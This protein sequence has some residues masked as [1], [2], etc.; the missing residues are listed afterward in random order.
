MI[1]QPSRL[2]A[3]AAAAMGRAAAVLRRSAR[4]TRCIPTRRRCSSSRRRR[5]RQGGIE[6]WFE[7][8]HEDFGVDAATLPQADRHARRVVRFGLD[9]PDGDGRS[10]RPRDEHA[11][12]HPDGHRLPGRPLPRRLRPAS[13]LVPFVA[14]RSSCMLN[15][16][17]PYKAL[18]THGFAV[19]GEGRKMSKSKGNVVAP[20]KVSD[21]LGA[22]N[23]AAVGRAR[24]T[25]RATSSI[26]DEILKRVVESYRRIRNTLRFLIAN[27]ADFDAGAAMRVA[28]GRAVRDR[29]LRARAGA[30]AGRR[31]SPA[32]YA[33]YEFHLVVQRLQTY[34]SED[35]GG[36]Y[37]DVLK[38]RLYT[39]ARD[40]RAP[41][42]G[43][44]GARADPRRA[45]AADGADPVVHGRGGVADRAS[46]GSDDLRAH[47]GRRAAAR[48]P[49]ADALR[50]EVGH[51]SSAV[52]ARVQKELEA[53]A[54][55]RARS[56]HRCR[57]TSTI[58]APDADVSRR[59]RS[60]GDDL[61]FVLITSAATRRRAAT[62]LARSPSRRA[63][64]RSASAAGTGAPTSAPI[65]RIRRCAVAASRTCS[66]RASRAR[67]PEP[68]LRA[69]MTAT[70]PE[71][72]T[73]PAMAVASPRCHRRR[74]G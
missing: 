69:R 9:A 8:T 30:G 53:A 29:S 45:A 54:P 21:T 22:G 39:T 6:A 63:R 27:T 47:V 34:C 44:D 38:D 11:G 74:P 33:R 71:P 41:P 31:R 67:S 72:S 70:L 73:A 2:D 4:P 35:L 50:R 56:A 1:A 24:P 25:T 43:A 5:W 62:T 19:D 68:S 49:S 32:D 10:R 12:S 18:L 64:T 37:L 65:R 13:R 58:V 15:G 14:A 52:R 42:L 40:S 46:R 48:L 28:G 17:P 16:V 36:F 3:V 61:R 60:L 57:P 66:A 51:A 23:P 59:W 20:Q 26:S 55:V 7:A